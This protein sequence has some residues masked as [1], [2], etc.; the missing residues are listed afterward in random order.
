MGAKARILVVD[1]NRPTALII[2]SVLKKRGY[3]VFTAYDGLEGFRMARKIKP[4]LL[5]LDIMMPLMDG[6]EV[7]RRLKMSP[8]TAGIT[9]LM[10]TAKG[11]IDKDVGDIDK[12]TK[13]QYKFAQCVKDRAAGFDVGATEFLTKPIKAKELVQRVKSLLWA[14]GF[15]D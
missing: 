4:D 6:Y 15:I 3:E 7:C 1:D 2:S 14:S 9:V 13:R 10:L 8:A 11:G 5:I 12:D